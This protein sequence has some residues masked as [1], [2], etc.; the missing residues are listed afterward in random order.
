MIKNILEK[1]GYSPETNGQ[2][3]RMKALYR[4][5]NSNSLAVNSQTGWF[6]DFV[7][8][9][10]GPLIKLAMMTLNIGE[11][12]A[13]TFLHNKYFEDIQVKQDAET[14]IV[15]D[16]SFDKSFFDDTLPSY[17]FYIKRGISENTL[18]TFEVGVKTYGKM[19]NR[20]VFPIYDFNFKIIG[21]AGRDL[22]SSEERAK[23]KILGRKNNF[24]YPFHISEKEI[25]EKNSV[26]LVESIGDVLRLYEYGIK[27]V[28]VLFG[29]TVSKNLMLYLIR[30]NVEKII[31]AT[32]NDSLS[33]DNRG[34]DAAEKNKEKLLK[35]FSNDKIKINLPSKKD[36]GEMNDQEIQKWSAAIL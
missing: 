26:I 5:S 19:N 24:V 12:E 10:N 17:N 21:L 23:W 6:N 7:T 18:K 25:I 35:F 16:K 14:K 27:N 22:F 15:Q 36:F 34:K 13:K 28:L 3:Y 2:W 11:S 30:L 9:E 1:M 31:I 4:N 32:N 33:V 20:I 29:L 8:G